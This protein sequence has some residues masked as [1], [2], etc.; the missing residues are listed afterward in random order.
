MFP[1]HTPMMPHW[2]GQG[3]CVVYVVLGGGGALVSRAAS[4]PLFLPF[5]F[6]SCYSFI[7][8]LLKGVSCH[9]K[10]LEFSDF[11]CYLDSSEMLE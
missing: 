9:L 3:L 11:L 1:V 2:Q 10:R 4:L 6:C 8:F 5:Y 7:I